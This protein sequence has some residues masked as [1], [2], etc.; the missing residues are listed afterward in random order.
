[1]TVAI[2]TRPSLLL[3]SRGSESKE[4][5]N[6]GSGGPPRHVADPIHLGTPGLARYSVSHTMSS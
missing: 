5:G 4:R 3:C 1:M 6:L 2:S